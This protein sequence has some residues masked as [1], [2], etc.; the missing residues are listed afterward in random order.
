MSSAIEIKRLHC[1]SPKITRNG[2]NNNAKQ[3]CRCKDCGVRFISG[4]ERSYRGALSWIK[5][6][7]NITLGWR[8]GMR[9]IS[10]AEVLKALKSG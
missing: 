3:N 7:I 5:T 9:D 2:K 4:D 8:I 6:V 10:V 1:R